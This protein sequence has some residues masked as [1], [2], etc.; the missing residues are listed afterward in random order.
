M[1]RFTQNENDLIRF[2]AKTA[3]TAGASRLV[4][5]RGWSTVTVGLGWSLVDTALRRTNSKK[6]RV[7]AGIAALG[8]AA[9]WLKGPHS[10]R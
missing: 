2:L 4:R 8:V 10:A 5:S 7:A 6:A 1:R 9:L 3:L